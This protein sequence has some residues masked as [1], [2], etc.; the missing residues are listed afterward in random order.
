MFEKTPDT[1][2]RSRKPNLSVQDVDRITDNVA[3]DSSS[4]NR[5]E[6][7]HSF[8]E[9]QIPNNNIHTPNRITLLLFVEQN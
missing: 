1:K 3:P 5:T 7:I 6:I 2:Q 8:S 9:K 4:V